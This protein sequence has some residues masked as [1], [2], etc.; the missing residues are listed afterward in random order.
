MTWWRPEVF[1]VCFR[2]RLPSFGRRSVLVSVHDAHSTWTFSFSFVFVNSFTEK[3][4]FHKL[5]V[6]KAL[7]GV[8][9]D[10][11]RPLPLAG[12]SK[13]CWRSTISDLLVP[14]TSNCIR[15]AVA[16]QDL[17]PS[18]P[19]QLSLSLSLSLS[20]KWQQLWHH[21]NH[22]HMTRG[23]IEKHVRCSRILAQNGTTIT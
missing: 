23:M 16:R 22:T 2:F 6:C 5:S 1:C 4:K 7:H 19:V 15:W 12:Y 21:E 9:W 11:C 20:L 18:G 13:H 14:R 17:G 10:L 3:L 8:S